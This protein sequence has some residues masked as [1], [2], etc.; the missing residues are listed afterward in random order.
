MKFKKLSK[1]TILYGVIIA[2]FVYLLLT[3]CYMST[4]IVVTE[5]VMDNRFSVYGTMRCGYTVKMLDHLKAL[6]QSVRF[7]DVSIPEGDAE[8]K[9]VTEGKNIR[10][11]PFTIDHK[12]S[13]TISGF[14]TKINL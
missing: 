8:F 13:E 2:L 14:Q 4:P 11:I 10:G 5:P 9:N 3:K 7:V 12:T 1:K 6:G